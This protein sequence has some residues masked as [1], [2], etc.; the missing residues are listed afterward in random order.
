MTLRRL[1]LAPFVFATL[2]F[3]TPASAAGSRSAPGPGPALAVEDTMH[4]EVPPV[5]VSAPRVTLDEIL[6]RVARGEAHRDSLVRDQSYVLTLRVVGHVGENRPAQLLE[7]TVSQVWLRPPRRQVRVLELRHWELHPPKDDKRDV[8][9]EFSGG[10]GEDIVNFAFQPRA[11]REY[12]YSIEGRELRG[13]HLVYRIAFEPRS[14]LF[15]AVLDAVSKNRRHVR[16]PRR[17]SPFGLLPEA[18]RR[19]TELMLTGIPHQA[20]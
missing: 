18:P 14:P 3:A 20:R 11:R 8:K 12:R 6:D 2:A 15:G 4:T 7:E 9:V 10:T 1:T 19:I 5:L 17:T 13:D 16:L